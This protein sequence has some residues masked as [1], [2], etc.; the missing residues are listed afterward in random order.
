MLG[1]SDGPV[2]TGPVAGRTAQT[3]ASVQRSM[4]FS[5]VLDPGVDATGTNEPPVADFR[6]GCA[7]LTCE[8]DGSFS[9]DL[10][11]DTLTYTWDFGD[12]TTGTGVE[13]S[14]TYADAGHPHR[15]PHRRRRPRP[16]RE[17]DRPGDRRRRRSRG[18]ATPAWCR[19]RRA[20]TSR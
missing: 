1:D 7:G 13:P 10:D 5:V 6:T 9:Y 4:L 11:G 14:H 19:T 18:P 3:Q 20:P 15:P 17:Q 8:L 16:H 2:P 12:G